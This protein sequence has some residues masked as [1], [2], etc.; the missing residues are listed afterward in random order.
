LK[1]LDIYL[2]KRFL[3]TFFFIL[4]V[5]M[6]IAVIFD[7]SER[8]DDFLKSDAPLKAIVF[9]YYL[10]FVLYYA[11]LFSSLLIFISVILFTAKLASNSEIVAILS[12]GISFN[13]LLIPYFIA[14]SILAISS[15]YLNHYVLPSANK[16]RLE[17]EENFIRNQFTYRGKDVHRQI[18]PG[19]FIYFQTYNSSKDIGYKFS[20]EKWKDFKMYYKLNSS[21]IRWDSTM[22]KWSVEGY[23]VRTFNGLKETFKTGAKLDTVFSFTPKDFK[24]RIN[25]TSMMTTPELDKYIEEE[26]MRGSDNIPYYLI[27]KYQRTSYPFA[28]Y[29]LTLIGVSI[30]SRKV[31][32]G[33]G[34]HIAIGMLI[35]VSYILIMKVTTVYA[36]NAGFDPFIAVWL[37]NAIFGVFA[38]F[39]FLRAPK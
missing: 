18:S 31:R 3:I 17:F 37:P 6:L 13:R 36:T 20:L 2:I 9:E 1:K 23:T 32:G 8:I 35:A 24:R 16:T 25:N 30:A 33:I 11:N 10:N 14:A 38:I 21:F 15:W 34:F 19:E 12:S 27:E 28:T 5:I 4:G 7:I 26:T 39:I 22:S 29:I